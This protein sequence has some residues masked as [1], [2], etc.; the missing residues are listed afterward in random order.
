MEKYLLLIL[1]VNNLMW[2]AADVKLQILK[3][4]GN[5][6]SWDNCFLFSKIVETAEVVFQNEIVL[7]QGRTETGEKKW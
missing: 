2:I 4:E 7:R 3:L 6:V 1:K 5:H